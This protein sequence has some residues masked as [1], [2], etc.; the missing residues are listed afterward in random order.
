VKAKEK[1]PTSSFSALFAMITYCGG[2][3]GEETPLTDLAG[4]RKYF[5]EGV[6]HKTHPH[7]PIAL[8]GCFKNASR[9]EI[10]RDPTNYGFLTRNRHNFRL[11][12]QFSTFHVTIRLYNRIFRLPHARSLNLVDQDQLFVVTP[13]FSICCPDNFTSNSTVDGH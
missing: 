7:V 3:Q 6:T 2:L 8:L 9:R 10:K 11:N 12:C 5:L 13:D 1:G 4:M